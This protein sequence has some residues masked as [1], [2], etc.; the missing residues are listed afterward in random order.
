[1]SLENKIKKAFTE[2][3]ITESSLSRVAQH[4]AEH[5]TGF[6]TAF[7][8]EYPNKQNTL[9]NKALKSFLVSK[10]YG[11]TAVNGSYIENYGT[12]KAK[13]VKEATYFVVDLNDTGN[14]E[15]VLREQGEKW[16]QDSILFIPKGTGKGVLWGTR[17]GNEYPEF[18]QK[19]DLGNRVLGKDGEFMTKVKGRPFIFETAVLEDLSYATGRNGRMGANY[20]YTRTIKELDEL[21]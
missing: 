6:I 17:Q 13:E 5:D 7:R 16:E 3:K 8:S 18:K 2:A 15:S 19:I 11:I 4:M 12:K 21:V 10:G 1:M 9:R 14:L 20:I